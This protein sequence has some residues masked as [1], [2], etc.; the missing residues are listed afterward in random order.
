M[1]DPCGDICWH[2]TEM[3]AGQELALGTFLLKCSAESAVG[4]QRC[5]G[6]HLYRFYIDNYVITVSF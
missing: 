5:D 6:Q 2:V 1:L 3:Y 4:C